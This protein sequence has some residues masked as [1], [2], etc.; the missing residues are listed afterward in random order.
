VNDH[1]RIL[2]P[3]ARLILCPSEIHRVL[4]HKSPVAVEDDLLQIP[5]LE[6]GEPESD[7]MTRFA[8]ALRM[9]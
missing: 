8:V 3:S 1:I 4:G 6:P 7:D 5:I 9:R 2:A